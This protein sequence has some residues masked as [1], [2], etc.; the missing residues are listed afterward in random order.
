[1]PFLE[2]ENYAQFIDSIDTF[3]LDCD[4]VIWHGTHV[5]DGIRELLALLRSKGKRLLFVTNNSTNSRKSYLK[6]FTKLGIEAS[7][8]EIFGSAYAAACYVSQILKFPKDKKVYV[9]GMS[10]IAE[11]LAS[12]GINYCGVDEDNDNLKEMSEMGTVKNDPDVGAVLFGFDLNINYKKLAKAFTYLHHNPECHFLATN[13]DLTF[14][15][16]GT[17]YPGTGALLSALS[18][19][20]QRKPTVLGKPEKTMLDV[21]VAKYHLDRDRTCMV[22]DRLDTDIL[23]GQSGNLKTLLVMTGVTSHDQLEKSAIQ[24]DYYI[25]KLAD[26]NNH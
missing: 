5:L 7:E 13:S 23:F 6:K 24:P 19:P 21:I 15:A 25:E 11:E 9:C 4:G 17:V 8:D 3:L 14:P 20:L 10:G 22:G 16:G 1:M 26:L 18:A 2:Q 12:E